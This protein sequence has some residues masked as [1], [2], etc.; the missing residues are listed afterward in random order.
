[1]SARE[2]TGAV[3][4]KTYQPPPLAPPEYWC[5]LTVET[6]TGERLRFRLHRRQIRQVEVG[7]RIRFSRP[8]T[9]LSVVRVEVLE[10]DS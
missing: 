4:E 2:M 7:D 6:D 5:Y 9:R 10:R 1:M 3:L 8:L